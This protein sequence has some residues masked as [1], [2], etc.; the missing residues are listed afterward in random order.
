MLNILSFHNKISISQRRHILSI[1]TLPATNLVSDQK[2]T[3]DYFFLH[4][5]IG[6]IIAADYRYP[7]FQDLVR[8]FQ[9][10][11]GGYS[12]FSFLIFLLAWKNVHLRLHPIGISI[13]VIGCVEAVGDISKELEARAD[14]KQELAGRFPQTKPI[15]ISSS[16]PK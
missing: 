3:C 7:G 10:Y 11:H 14:T 9:G 5:M 13:I 6:L 8:H 15:L 4:D 1:Y 16:G 12:L 2:N